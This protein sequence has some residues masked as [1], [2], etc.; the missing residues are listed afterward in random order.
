[1]EEEKEEEEE[2]EAEKVDGCSRF[3]CLIPSSSSSFVPLGML[4]KSVKAV[5]MPFS[6]V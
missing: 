6:F 5:I 2:E 3:C 4:E 1:M